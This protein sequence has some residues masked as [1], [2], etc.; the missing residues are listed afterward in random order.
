MMRVGATTGNGGQYNGERR[1]LR[2]VAMKNGGGGCC[3]ED[4]DGGFSIVF[5][6]KKVMRGVGVK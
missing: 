5:L 1:W 2:A 3:K 4:E 6:Q